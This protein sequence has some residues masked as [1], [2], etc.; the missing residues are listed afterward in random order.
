MGGEKGSTEAAGAAVRLL[1]CCGRCRD[2]PCDI[3]HAACAV[4]VE[5]LPN[6]T[7]KA[8]MRDSM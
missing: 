1:G 7:H 6:G 5:Q 4:D 8:T 3:R 2:T